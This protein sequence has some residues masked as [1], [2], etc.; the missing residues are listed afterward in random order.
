MGASEAAKEM[1]GQ[2]TPATLGGGG[3]DLRPWG[4]GS[5]RFWQRPVKH[6]FEGRLGSVLFFSRRTSLAVGK[7]IDFKFDLI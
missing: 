4:W 1:A 2:A 5:C 3:S 6:H 7:K